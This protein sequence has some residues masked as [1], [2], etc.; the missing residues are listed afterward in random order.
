MDKHLIMPT[1]RKQGDCE[2]LL[3]SFEDT[4]GDLGNCFD[5][6]LDEKKTKLNVIGSIFGFGASLTKLSFKVL[7]CAI[8]NTPKVIVA[9]AAVKREIVNEL[10][11]EYNQYQKELKEDAL[12][13]KIKQLQLKV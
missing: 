4:I 10:E 5:A 11:S 13:E 7:G 1:G 9:V 2:V 8:K 3:D 12:N 6:M